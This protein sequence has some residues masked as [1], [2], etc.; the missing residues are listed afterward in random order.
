MKH[1]ACIHTFKVPQRYVKSERCVNDVVPLSLLAL[2]NFIY[3]SGVST[4]NSERVNT[5]RDGPDLTELEEITEIKNFPE[6]AC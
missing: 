2:N 6:G 5:F 4:V 1:S 3:F